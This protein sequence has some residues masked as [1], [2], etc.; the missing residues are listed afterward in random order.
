MYGPVIQGSHFR[1]RPPRAEEAETMVGWFEDMEVTSRLGA[2][3]SV[4]SPEM[5]REWLKRMAEDRNSMLWAIEREAQLIGT[6]GIHAIDWANQNGTTGTLIGDKT[7]WGKGI[8]AELMRLR[9][10]FAFTELPLRKL[11]SGYVEGNEASRRAQEGAGYREVG[12]LRGEIF[13]DG[14]WLDLILTELQR[15]DWERARSRG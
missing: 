5:E 15:E 6:T 10:D 8:A 4:P 13:R 2:G 12:R 11:K 7:A 9:A 3:R 14:R 1:L